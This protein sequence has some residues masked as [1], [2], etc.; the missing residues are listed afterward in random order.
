MAVGPGLRWEETAGVA[1]VEAGAPL[2]PGH[3]FRIGS[4]TKMFVAAVA[5]GLAGAYD[6]LDARL[7]PYRQNHAYRPQLTARE[8]LG[9]VQG[10]PRLFP[11]GAGWSYGG[12][13]YHASVGKV[14]GCLAEGWGLGCEAWRKNGCGGRM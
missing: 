11:P 5:S 10:K 8:E 13:N 9:L 1:D 6:D 12:G 14:V 3:R 2:M 4:V 7:E